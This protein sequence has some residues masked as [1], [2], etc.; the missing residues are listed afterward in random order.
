VEWASETRSLIKVGGEECGNQADRS[1]LPW[2]CNLL[3]F[4]SQNARGGGGV[5][6][7]GERRGQFWGETGGKT[8]QDK[9]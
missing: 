8:P 1:L 4:E 7:A 6:G 2:C 9:N 3:H 5:G